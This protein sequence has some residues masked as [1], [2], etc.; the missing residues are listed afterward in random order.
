RSLATAS[1][2]GTVKL[3]EM[4]RQD[5]TMPVLEC[6]AT[7]QGPPGTTA[8]L[9]PDLSRL[10]V[11]SEDNK[12]AVWNVPTQE[13]IAQHDVPQANAIM[14][15]PNRDQIV[16]MTRGGSGFDIRDFT[17]HDIASR[18]ADNSGVIQRV[19]FSPS[20]RTFATIS[21]NGDLC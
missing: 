5:G 11:T 15:A 8:D 18:L 16:A 14:F 17:G 4:G 13:Q 21:E 10:M 9:S 6:P 12:V 20:G 2:D 19:S 3:W 7:Y 1:F